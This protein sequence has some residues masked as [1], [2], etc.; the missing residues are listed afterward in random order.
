MDDPTYLPTWN[1]DGGLLWV[2]SEIQQRSQ[3]RFASP[4]PAGIDERESY[5][6]NEK[7][8]PDVKEASGGYGLG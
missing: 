7:K 4:W 6:P 1:A 8:P 5:V 3:D 2:I